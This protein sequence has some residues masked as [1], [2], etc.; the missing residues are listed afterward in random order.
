MY[1]NCNQIEGYL[2]KMIN[3]KKVY[4]TKPFHKKYFVI[5]FAYPSIK[6]YN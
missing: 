6:I 5:V 3:N 1:L 2:M 4:H